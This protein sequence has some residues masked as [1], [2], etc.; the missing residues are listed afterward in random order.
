MVNSNATHGGSRKQ[1][2][3]GEEYHERS[4]NLHHSSA[5]YVSQSKESYIFTAI[6]SQQVSKA[7]VYTLPAVIFGTEKDDTC[8]ILLE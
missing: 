7:S 6:S 3:Y 4:W 8:L 2:K 1:T 5:P